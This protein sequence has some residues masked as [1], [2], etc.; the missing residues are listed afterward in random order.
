MDDGD[1]GCAG[2]RV[3]CGGQDAVALVIVVAD[4][5]RGLAVAWA[6]DA[7]HIGGRARR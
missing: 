4:L 2:A 3:V 5:S 7:E 6:Q 1:E